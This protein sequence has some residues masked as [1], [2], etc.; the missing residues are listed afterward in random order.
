MEARFDK[1]D[2]EP[3]TEPSTTQTSVS[4]GPPAKRRRVSACTYLK[5]VW[6]A[7]YAQE[8]RLWDSHDGANK[9]KKSDA[10]ILVAFMKLFIS[11]GF[12]LYE[13]SATCRDDVMTL[14]VEA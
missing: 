13:H 5:D 11:D 2:P 4:S 10:K 6:F 3:L 7:W 1:R 9:R 12:R 14:G 8:P